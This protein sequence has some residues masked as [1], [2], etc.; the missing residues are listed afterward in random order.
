MCACVRQASLLFPSIIS[1]SLRTFWLCLV[2]FQQLFHGH[3][4]SIESDFSSSFFLPHIVFYSLH[5]VC[6]C[7][8]MPAESIHFTLMHGILWLLLENSASN[9]QVIPRA[10]S[11]NLKYRSCLLL[12]SL[13]CSIQ[14]VVVYSVQMFVCICVCVCLCVFRFIYL[15]TLFCRTNWFL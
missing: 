1:I 2:S 7:V 9:F 13:P 14:L 4:C 3:P 5:S 11:D 6:L 8:C 15:Y 10:S 12:A